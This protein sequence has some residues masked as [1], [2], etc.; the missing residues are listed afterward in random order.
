M[1]LVE[2]TRD[3]LEVL[4]EYWYAL[5][6][7]M[8][9]YDD[10][11]EVALDGPADAEDGLGRQLDRDDTTVYLLVADG[12]RVGYLLLRTGEHPSRV[13]SEYADVV[14]LFV[15]P[16][17]RGK[18]IGSEAIDAVKRTARDRGAEYV[19]VSCEWHN[20]GARRFYVD[21]GFEPKQ[22]TYV[23]RLD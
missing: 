20:D 1:E 17:H 7:A 21:N 15:A 10:L 9:P 3:D 5:A 8:E 19:T 14:D 18:G 4:T 12:K 16:E 6:T 13:R 23:H 11:N 22:V 2:A